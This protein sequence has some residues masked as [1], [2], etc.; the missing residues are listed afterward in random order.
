M[1]TSSIRQ[2]LG[3]YLAC[4]FLNKKDKG[5]RLILVEAR[6]LDHDYPLNVNKVKYRKSE[7]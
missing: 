5:L 3:L 1:D 4:Q 6:K 7:H 2:K